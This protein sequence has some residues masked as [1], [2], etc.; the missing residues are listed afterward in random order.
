MTANIV[1][2]LLNDA[3]VLFGGLVLAVVG[4]RLVERRLLFLGLVLLHFEVHQDLDRA[5]YVVDDYEAVY[6]DEPLAL[7][8][9]LAL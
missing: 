4:Q 7:G 5:L 6:V 2:K 1:F 3:L 9:E 8:F